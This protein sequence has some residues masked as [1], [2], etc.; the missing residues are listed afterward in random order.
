MGGHI[1]QE[2]AP[3][4]LIAESVGLFLK[5][6]V[7]CVQDLLGARVLFGLQHPIAGQ[8]DPERFFGSIE[9]VIF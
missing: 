6:P 3:Q 9:R 7:G 4:F 2:R 8:I 1:I 5:Q